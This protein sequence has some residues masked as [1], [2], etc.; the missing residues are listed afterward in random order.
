MRRL[1]A[2][3]LRLAATFDRGRLDRELA[4]ELEG[5]LAMAIDDNLRS[6]MTAEEA[7]RQALLKLGG[8][9]QVEERYRDRR[10]IPLLE[11]LARDLC[12]SARMLRRNPGFTAV[13]VLTLG[14]GIG[15]NTAIFSVVN[16]VLLRPLPFPQ[17][18][19]LVLVWAT[20]KETGNTADVAS[21]PDFEEW[22]AR[23]RSFERMAAFTTRGVTLAGGGQAE[24]VAAVQATPGFFETL[25][26][27]P[28]LGRTFRPEESEEGAPHVA[29]LSD[30]SWRRYF[31]GRAD[32]LGKTIRANEE[33]YTIV[34]V[35]PRGFRLAFTADAPE[36][37]YAPLVRDPSRN[38]GFLRVLGA[39]R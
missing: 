37:I 5:H 31:G 1:R 10:G 2:W 6:G 35:M 33:I 22:R 8:V 28:A 39:T 30:S 27:A 29:L 15:A 21:Y 18:D 19:R 7:R 17:S 14:L 3:L 36:Q 23:S 11:N 12:F 34:G 4:A 24:L 32:V 25:G 16:A 38:H 26:V 9:A 13:A 20:N